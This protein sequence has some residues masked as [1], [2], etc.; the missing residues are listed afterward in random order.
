MGRQLSGSTAF[1]RSRNS[2]WILGLLQRCIGCTTFIGRNR[3]LL[4]WRR[5]L[6]DKLHGLERAVSPVH[7]NHWL[8]DIPRVVPAGAID[9]TSFPMQVRVA[10][11][12][13]HG[14]DAVFD[15][16]ARPA[17]AA[18]AGQCESAALKTGSTAPA[19]NHD[20]SPEGR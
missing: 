20:P 19:L 14:L 5:C 12:P 2:W 3:T 10:R 11:Q 7:E 8:G 13:I 17:V 4:G 15:E 18:K 16:G 6:E 1:N 9:A